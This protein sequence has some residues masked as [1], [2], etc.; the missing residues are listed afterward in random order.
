MR[1]SVPTAPAR[2]SPQARMAMMSSVVQG[3]AT[4][5]R[6]GGPHNPEGAP[7]GAVVVC[8]MPFDGDPPFA[9][10]HLARAL[11]Q[12]RPVLAVDRPARLG[13]GVT[14][15]VRAV[16]TNLWAV[17]PRCLPRADRRGWSVLS[18]PLVGLDIERAARQVMPARRALITLAP[19]RGMLPLLKRDV[20]VYWRRDAAADGHYV[21]SV[22]HVF[23]RHERLLARADLVTAVSPEL[24]ADRAAQRSRTHY[25][26]NGAD[27]DLFAAAT[28]PPPPLRTVVGPVIGYLGAVSWRF[29]TDL[30]DALATARPEWTF[31]L[32]GDQQVPVPRRDNV[33][34]LGPKPYRELPAWAQRFD[35]GLVPYRNETFNRSSFPLKVFDYLAAGVPVVA[36]PL[37]ALS[38]LDPYVRTAA[39]PH[40]F[41]DAIERALA[42]GP[43]RDACRCV[44]EANSWSRRAAQLTGLVDALLPTE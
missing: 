9:D 38:A 41:L 7:W 19:S 10:T 5:Q 16:G 1:I 23:A 31:V 30:L 34:A 43:S 20:T 33:W 25:L 24:V 11:A 6:G 39:D 4:L 15:G 22:D 36:P 35:V 42:E 26:P 12:Y 37:P 8:G 27:T 40:G 18:D 21:A 2:A 44:A 13:S 3:P 17:T 29:D 28:A 14:R 32:I